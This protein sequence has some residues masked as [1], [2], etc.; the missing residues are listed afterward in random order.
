MLLQTKEFQCQ[1]AE[2]MV[3]GMKNFTRSKAN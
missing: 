2:A 3:D 1:C